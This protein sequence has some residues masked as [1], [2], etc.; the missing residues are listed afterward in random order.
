MHTRMSL[1]KNESTTADMI[2]KRANPRHHVL[3]TGTIEFGGATIDCS[4]RNV[5]HAGAALNVASPVGIPE[6]FNLIV[7]SDK[8]RFACRV[9]YRKEKRI[10]IAFV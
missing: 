6:N 2:D 8:L 10:G 4:V 5:S 9:I 1:R 3:K 7:P